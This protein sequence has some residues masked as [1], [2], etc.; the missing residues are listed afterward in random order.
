MFAR[1]LI[2]EGS[3]NGG[4]FLYLNVFQKMEVEGVDARSLPPWKADD[5]KVEFA[6]F[7]ATKICAQV[8]HVGVNVFFLFMFLL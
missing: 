5:L 4:H 6:S 3:S 7:I 1:V 8:N 2:L